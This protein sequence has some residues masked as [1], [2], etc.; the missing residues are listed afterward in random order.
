MMYFKNM[1]TGTRGLK[2]FVLAFFVML[3]CNVFG[4]RSEL[5]QLRKKVVDELLVGDI[6]TQSVSTL[7]ESIK[8]EGCWANIDY[9]DVS[10]TG[11]QHGRHLNNLVEMS[12]AFKK[13]NSP[14]KGNLK[15]KESISLALNYWIAN[16]FICENWW[17]NQIG[18]PNALVSVL[19]LMDEELTTGQV[20]SI[21][22]IVGRAHLAASGARPSGDR[23]KI[24]G[25]LAKKLLFQRNEEEFNGVI[26]VIEGEIR[27]NT[28]LRGMQHDYS[29]HH[30]EDRVNNTL[31][32]G[33]GYAD[34]FAE[35]ASLVAGT[36]YKFGD[37]SLHQLVDYYLDGI[38]KQMIYGKYDDPGTKNRDIT[39]RDSHRPMGTKTPERLLHAT[40]YRA[41]ELKEIIALREENKKPSLSHSTF[42]WQ[43]EHFA[44]QRPGFFTSVRMF[45]MRNKNME[46]PYN[47]EGLFNHHRGD[48]TNY[49]CRR[50]DEYLNIA[51]VYDWQKIP[52]ATI[53]QK[54]ELPS[55]SKIQKKGLTDFVGAVSDGKYGAVVFDFKSPHDS[56]EARK[57]WFFFDEEY[58][59]LGTGIS[60]ASE[61]SLATTLNQC[62]LAGEVKIKQ[63]DQIKTLQA[64]SNEE[65]KH[66][67][68]ILHD[69]IGYFFPENQPLNLSNQSQTGSWYK[70]N[71]Q[72]SSPKK[73]ISLDVFKL[74][75]NHGKQVQNGNYQ[76]IIAPEVTVDELENF[77]D[78][79]VRV[80][81]N[82][83]KIQAVSHSGLNIWQMVFYAPGKLS[84]NSD[85]TLE[86][87]NPALVMLKR[88]DGKISQISVSDPSRKLKEIALTISERIEK[89]GESYQASWNEKNGTSCV[90]ISLP[91][92]VYAG[93]SVTLDF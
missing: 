65:L 39:R 77:A 72:S 56:V 57:A 80:V 55:E 86:C 25:I 31:S 58:V 44:F 45:S 1:P 66:V 93:K 63:G 21:L 88:T 83:E 64:E 11:F 82:D 49:I 73:E 54:P 23:I 5:Q 69:S 4:F 2:Y 27:F 43:T 26:R 18:T 32:Y 38:C 8:P 36:S 7:M 17:W 29:F 51:P 85:L 81:S 91:Q 52:G 59:C 87:N 34:A 3:H 71:N 50:G 61:N 20:N 22:P 37:K 33:L 16:D 6:N 19:L 90:R 35:W 74:W 53:L 15:L 41:E 9:Q 30:R 67:K 92:S 75:I 70:I 42:F 14:M 10:R 68:W 62:L 46:E 84:M 40:V 13:E 89:N 24:A 48:G 12:R 76:Y 78:R 28:G 60:A 47:G 79:G